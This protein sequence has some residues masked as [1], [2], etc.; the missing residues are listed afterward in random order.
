MTGVDLEAETPKPTAAW[1]ESCVK[2][3]I[4]QVCACIRM[5]GYVCMQQTT[6]THTKV[7]IVCIS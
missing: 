7:F 3:I 1:K 4:P 2:A 5:Y 6:T